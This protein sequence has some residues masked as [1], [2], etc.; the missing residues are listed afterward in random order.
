MM[1]TIRP[2]LGAVLMLLTAFTMQSLPLILCRGALYKVLPMVMFWVPLQCI[3]DT[4]YAS[5]QFWEAIMEYLWFLLPMIAG[6]TLGWVLGLRFRRI[7]DA[8]RRKAD[9]EEKP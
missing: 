9:G 6:N 3:A 4:A 8:E 5:G 2:I 1:E 7:I